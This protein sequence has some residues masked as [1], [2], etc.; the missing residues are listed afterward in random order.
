MAVRLSAHDR[1]Q[2]QKRLWKGAWAWYKEPAT[3]QEVFEFEDRVGTSFSSVHTHMDRIS[4]D[5]A[6]LDQEVATLNS[7]LG[8]G[9][10]TISDKLATL[11]R[12][13][14]LLHENIEYVKAD[15]AVMKAEIRQIGGATREMHEGIGRMRL[16]AL[17]G[18][19]SSS[20]ARPSARPPH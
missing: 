15:L 13:Q 5:V 9:L 18:P 20:S 17:R 1:R 16:N 11:L 14:E 8:S 4:R 6:E 19:A 7:R 2:L 10:G 3:R 12:N